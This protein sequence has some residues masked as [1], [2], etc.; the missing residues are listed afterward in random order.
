MAEDDFK[1]G[2]FSGLQMESPLP[3]WQCRRR[4]RNGSLGFVHWACKYGY[5]HRRHEGEQQMN[6]SNCT[7]FV[8]MKSAGEP[9][10]ASFASSTVC[11]VC[12]QDFGDELALARH[13][14]APALP[15]SEVA[16]HSCST[17][18]R[19]FHSSRALDQ[20]SKSCQLQQVK[21]LKGSA[22]YKL[23]P[24]HAIPEKVVS[25]EVT[26]ASEEGLRLSQLARQSEKLRRYMPSKAAAKRA[27]AKGEL[28]LNGEQV[29]EARILKA[30]DVVLLCLDRAQE[31][32]DAT[33][34][35]A[36][37]VKMVAPKRLSAGGPGPEEDS[38]WKIVCSTCPDGAAV[39]WK[40]TGMRSLGSHAGTLQ[41]S[42]PLVPEVAA[43]EASL[44]QPL[45]RLE[46]GCCGL[47]LV[48]LTRET[49]QLLQGWLAAGRVVHTFRAMLHGSL[50]EPGTSHVLT[51]TAPGENCQAASSDEEIADQAPPAT[52]EGGHKVVCAVVDV[53]DETSVVDL[54][55]TASSGRCCGSLCHLMRLQGT[56]VVGDKL[57]RRALPRGCRDGGN[58]KLRRFEMSADFRR[59][60]YFQ[61]KT[62]E[63]IPA[64]LGRRQA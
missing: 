44:L 60:F 23:S 12:L 32:L 11:H 50:G 54:R 2:V 8:F 30:G 22:G 57:A 19:R 42:L 20:H 36:R 28:M 51:S 5:E 37:S 43:L 26:I 58:G 39:V 15:I 16:A 62:K 56:P 1:Q 35:R 47:S 29:E 24:K 63:M 40:P 10:P 55:T 38:G 64:E 6:I 52:Q 14:E 21:P 31:A 17:C 34:A 41:S 61:R 48:G 33:T 4:W 7:T 27:I 46:I 59:I 3:E 25:V 53:Q 13:I 9:A 45:S 18:S 49:V